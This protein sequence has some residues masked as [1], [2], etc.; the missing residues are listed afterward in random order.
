MQKSILVLFLFVSTQWNC[1]KNSQENLSADGH[2]VAIL[3]ATYE[4]VNLFE[5]IQMNHPQSMVEKIEGILEAYP[6]SVAGYRITGVPQVE[7]SNFYYLGS[8]S[9]QCKH[10]LLLDQENLA[11]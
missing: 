3:P 6:K 5:L 2:P 9:E 8:C 4:P 10:P 11:R 1:H 7:K